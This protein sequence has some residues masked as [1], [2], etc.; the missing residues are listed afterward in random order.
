MSSHIKTIDH[1]WMC[2][3]LHFNIVTYIVQHVLSEDLAVSEWTGIGKSNWAVF[4][5]VWNREKLTVKPW[6]RALGFW[7][8]AFGN[9]SSL[10]VTTHCTCLARRAVHPASDRCVD[11]AECG[12]NVWGWGSVVWMPCREIHQTGEHTE[13]I[14]THLWPDPA[15][16]VR[17]CVCPLGPWLVTNTHF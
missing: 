17:V 1:L 5:T 4:T 13:V 3:A 10:L 2:F 8:S 16:C 14:T 9:V 11:C 6:G 15:L 7:L 12:R